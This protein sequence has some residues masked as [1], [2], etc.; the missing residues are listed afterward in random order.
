MKAIAY[1]KG[2]ITSGVS[3]ATYKINGGS[4]EEP[5]DVVTGENLAKNKRVRKWCNESRK[6]NRW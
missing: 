5:G 3:T 1:R 6:C 4:T 2:M